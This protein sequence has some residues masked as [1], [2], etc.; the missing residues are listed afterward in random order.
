MKATFRGFSSEDGKLVSDHSLNLGVLKIDEEAEELGHE[1]M[2]AIAKGA[3]YVSVSL[4]ED[5]LERGLCVCKNFLSEHTSEDFEA[6]MNDA[7]GI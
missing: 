4:E 6:C 2:N 5:V 1:V 7:G 3:D